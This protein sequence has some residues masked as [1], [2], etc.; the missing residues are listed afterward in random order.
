MASGDRRRHALECHIR[1]IFSTPKCRCECRR[2]CRCECRVRMSVAAARER[3]WNTPSGRPRC[4]AP[5]CRRRGCALLAGCMWFIRRPWAVHGRCMVDVWKMVDDDERRMG[6][7]WA[8]YGPR[9]QHPFGGVSMAS[10]LCAVRSV[11]GARVAVANHGGLR[12][13]ATRFAHAPCRVSR[14]APSGITM[15]QA[16]CGNGPTADWIY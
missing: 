13:T 14:F 2:E 9:A 11:C 6:G 5:P 1:E 7:V 12:R 4:G 15:R 16:R 3:A 8:G 10:M